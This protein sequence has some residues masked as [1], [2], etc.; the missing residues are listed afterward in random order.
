MT[1]LIIV[2]EHS[3]DECGM[4]TVEA[5]LVNEVMQETNPFCSLLGRE[6]SFLCLFCGVGP[7][8]TGAILQI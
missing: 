5:E 8:G 3:D 1:S 2:K 6:E 7:V 4:K